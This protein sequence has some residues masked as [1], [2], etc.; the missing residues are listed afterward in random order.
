[1]LKNARY[2]ADKKGVRCTIDV[3][4]V[5]EK[6]DLGYCE[7]TGIR[8]DYTPHSPFIPTLERIDS[9]K[10]YEYDNVVV[11]VWIYNRAKG[12]EGM[13][14]LDHFVRSYATSKVRS[15]E[16]MDLAMEGSGVVESCTA[17]ADKLFK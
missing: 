12:A 16:W 6:L 4:F 10:G 5:R 13:K 15:G 8:F 9:T 1:M 3:D 14:F 7:V 11:A 2:R 17:Q